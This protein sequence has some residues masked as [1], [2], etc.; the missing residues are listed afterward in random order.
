MII[1]KRNLLQVLKEHLKKKEISLI[2]GARQ[3]GKTT[4][5]VLLK[6]YL[7]KSA[8]DTLFLS[9]DNEMDKPFFATQQ[10]LLK[11]INLE[12][13]RR[14]AYVFID[15]IQRKENAGIF[16]KGLYDQNLP[17][18][19][20]VSGSGSLELKEKIHESLTGRK[21]LF[22]LG[23]ISFLEFLNFK[24]DYKYEQK[25]NDFFSLESQRTKSFLD[26]Y[27]NFGGYPRVI[28]E[29][30]L[31][32]K[33]KALDEIYHS[34]L[35]KDIS[36]LLKVEKIE[37]FTNLVK[38]LASQLGQLIN[39]NEIS[40]LLGISLPT[41]KNY[42]WYGEK[43]FVFNRLSPY[44]KNIRKEIT[45][46]P[47]VYFND[48]GLKNYSLGRFGNLQNPCDFGPVFENLIFKIIKEKIKFTSATVGFWR[49]TDKAEVDFVIDSGKNIIPIEVKYKQ[50][51]E[52]KIE[53]SLKSFIKKYS[54][55]KAFIV[56]LTLDTQ[57][58]IGNTKVFIIPFWKLLGEGL[59]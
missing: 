6:E 31:I 34:Y 59:N 11:K 15:E 4:L 41:L 29:E 56:N 1:I 27:L 53:R 48:L 40:S 54:P 9:L 36:Y 16:L 45:K 2:F 5:M 37:A 24:T 7:E 51:K 23:P 13:G 52:V 12:L 39:Y 25:I 19:F 35:E 43:T 22:E 42:F 20:I 50:M 28:L 49:T 17:Y 30:K 38:A 3:V 44:S 46:S 10:S 47:V 18:K 57:V 14:K 32:E 33:R 21:R 58:N 55:A 26:E 8:K